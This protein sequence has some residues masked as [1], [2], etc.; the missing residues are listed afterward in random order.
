MKSQSGN[1]EAQSISTAEALDRFK[2][3]MIHFEAQTREFDPTKTSEAGSLFNAKK[4]GL[5]N[6]RGVFLPYKSKQV[7][8]LCTPTR[9]SLNGVRGYSSAMYFALQ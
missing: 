7:C 8:I 3:R 1:R 2:K 9:K 6:T 4:H 5:I